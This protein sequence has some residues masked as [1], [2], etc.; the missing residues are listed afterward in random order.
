MNALDIQPICTFE[1]RNQYPGGCV[2]ADIVS[3]LRGGN[4]WLEE[5][6]EKFSVAGTMAQDDW[7][8]TNPRGHCYFGS[9]M[10]RMAEAAQKAPQVP[11]IPA[12]WVPVVDSK[13]DFWS[14]KRN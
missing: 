1:E 3:R 5:D 2:P 13:N 8:R 11:R 7:D 9:Y 14:K 12:S 4:L 10:Y 6:G